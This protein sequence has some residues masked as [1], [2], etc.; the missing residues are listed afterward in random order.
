MIGHLDRSLLEERCRKLMLE[1]ASLEALE[2]IG[3][4]ICLGSQLDKQDNVCKRLSQM[5]AGT[6]WKKQ[7]TG[8]ALE[9]EIL[10]SSSSS[11]SSS[12]DEESRS[13]AAS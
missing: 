8:R 4:C 11:S 1:K 9:Q 5:L 7:K 3:V 6:E 2:A 12:R 13:W 10:Q